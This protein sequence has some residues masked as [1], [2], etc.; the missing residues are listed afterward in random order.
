MTSVVQS[1]RIRELDLK[2]DVAVDSDTSRF[3]TGDLAGNDESI[4]GKKT[5]TATYKIKLTGGEFEATGDTHKITFGDFLQNAGLNKL[6]VGC[7]DVTDTAPGTW[8]FYPS[9][10]AASKTMTLDIYEKDPS[11]AKSIKSEIIGAISNLTINAD[12]IGSPFI[13]SFEAQ[14]RIDAVVSVDTSAI[15]AFDDSNVMRIVADK[16]L[17]TTIKVTNIL[18]SAS[19]T[20]CASKLSLESGNEI[21]ELECQATAAGILNKT[22]TAQNPKIVFDPLLTTLEEF[23]Y[24]EAL[25]TES[26]FKLEIDSEDIHIMVPRCQLMGS[27]VS[28]SNGF[29]R[30]EMTFRCLR[31]IDK[32]R[33]TGV[34]SLLVP[35]AKAVQAMYWLSFDEKL[36]DY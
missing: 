28:D 29:L 26:F 11:Q 1:N 15:P 3:L 13:A 32:D 2:V 33:P 31:N 17:S 9:V 5:A 21:A 22:I 24:W 36:A 4:T 20:F 27:S 30:N 6:G 34:T 10:D 25:S 8:V 16:F 19:M 14:G 18:T 7:T 35:D 23:N 12:G